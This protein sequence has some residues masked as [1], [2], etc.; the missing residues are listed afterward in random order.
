MMMDPSG[1]SGGGGG[2]FSHNNYG[3]DKNEFDSPPRSNLSSYMQSKLPDSREIPHAGN[4]GL[5]GVGAG[6]G[7]TFDKRPFKPFASFNKPVTLF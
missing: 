4:D 1:W 2:G 6:A 5:G 3:V 7:G